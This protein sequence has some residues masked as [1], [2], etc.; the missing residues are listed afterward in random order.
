[1]KLLF[2]LLLLHVQCY[3]SST[4]WSPGHWFSKTFLSKNWQAVQAYKQQDYEQSLTDI[5]ALMDQDPY[6]AEYNYNVGT[7]LYKQKKYNDAQQAFLRAIN[8]GSKTS[9]LTEQAFFNCG[10]CYYQLKSWQNAIDA[11]Q[12]VLKMNETNQQAEHNLQLALYMLKNEQLKK[13]QEDQSHNQDQKDQQKNQQCDNPNQQQSSD[14]DK[15]QSQQNQSDGASDSND[16]GND[17][18]QSDQKGSGKNKQKQQGVENG[19]SE[20]KQ[21]EKGS[22]KNQKQQSEQGDN[23]DDQ[24]GLEEDQ[25][26][27]EKNGN[28]KVEQNRSQDGMQGSAD[29]DDQSSDQEGFGQEEDAFDQQNGTKKG[30]GGYKK[31]EL[32]NQLQEKYE[33]KAYQDKRLNEYDASVIKT[34]EDLEEK[35]QKHVIKSKVAM[36][37]PGQNGKKSW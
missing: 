8:H 37:G 31:F 29:H 27:L 17:G 23:N 28:Q 12:N 13:Q 18:M 26:Q 1:M 36:Q 20:Q 3:A 7:V 24:K 21:Y 15:D 11:Y 16:Q 4:N 25:D 5:H 9:K 32:K 6:N 22:A 35:I 33:S 14:S 30:M 2:L 10:N 34:L 19:Q